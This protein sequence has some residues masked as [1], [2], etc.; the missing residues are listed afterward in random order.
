MPLPWMTQSPPPKGKPPVEDPFARYAVAAPAAQEEDPFAQYAVAAPRTLPGPVLD[1][2]A[3]SEEFTDAPP[4]AKSWLDTALHFASNA[5]QQLDPRPALKLI[6]DG[7]QAFNPAGGGDAG[8]GFVQDLKGIGGAQLEQFK[9]GKQAYDEGRISEAIGHT[10]AGVVPLMGPVAGNIGEQAGSGDISGALGA[11]TGLALGAKVVPKVL[12]KLIPTKI[13]GLA[14]LTAEEAAAVKQAQAA[15]VVVDAGTATGNAFVKGAQAVSDHSPLGSIVA[16]KAYLANAQNLATMGEQLAAKA[17]QTAEIGPQ[18]PGVPRPMI[19]GASVSAEQAGRSAQQAMG[20][21]VQDEQA[22]AIRAQVAAADTLDARG[23]QLADA[24]H[25]VPQT[26]ESAGTASIQGGRDVVH[27]RNVEASDAY[28]QLRAIEADPANLNTIRPAVAAPRPDARAMFIAQDKAPPNAIFLEALKDAKRSGFTGTAGELKGIFDERVKTAKA[29]KA[30]TESAG[31]EYGH[32][33]FLKSI[34]ELGGLK[35]YI[36]DYVPGAPVVKMTGE[37]D[38]VKQLFKGKG[39]SSIFR[40]KGLGLDDMVGQLRQDPRWSHVLTDESDLIAMLDDIGTKSRDG[41][42]T[43]GGDLQH[44]LR[45]A[46]VEPGVKWWETPKPPVDIPMATDLREFKSAI[47]PAFNDLKQQADLVPFMDGSGKATAYRALGRLIDGPDHA[48]LSVVDAALGELKSFARTDNPDLRSVGQGVA[49]AAIKKLDAVVRQTAWDAGPHALEALD[50]GRAATVAK[51]AA[52]DVLKR[53]EASNAE[54]VKAFGRLTAKA[55][56][57]IEHLREVVREVPHAAPQIGRA[58]IDG[59]LEQKDTAGS[60]DRAGKRAADWAALGPE[61][62]TL[63]FGGPEKVQ[64]LDRLFTTGSK[65]AEAH[66]AVAASAAEQILKR[67]SPGAAEPVGA[68]RG[69]TGTADSDI[70]HLRD[71]I[72]HAP[73]EAGKIGRAVLDGIQDEARAKTGNFEIT[74]TQAATWEKLGPETKRLLYRDPVYIKELDRYFAN[75]RRMSERANPSMSAVVGANMLGASTAVTS[76]VTGHLAAIPIL[77]SG[78]A[79]S[80][81]LHT[82]TGVRL[83]SEG[84]RLPTKSAAAVAQYTARVNA[85]LGKDAPAAAPVLAKDGDQAPG[86]V[87]LRMRK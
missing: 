36:K 6:Y 31:M 3:T 58:V 20:A 9:K 63:L 79:V 66:G 2:P 26:P 47:Q 60:F 43:G 80:K 76:A 52:A 85:V 8:A 37:F 84:L 19:P 30:E 65:L 34:R 59:I 69:L 86:E 10:V 87:Y 33:E 82:T 21:I 53:L 81:L 7:A 68:F 83:L 28:G 16:R 17:N 64:A 75:I 29:L 24:T 44:Y 12:P 54:P 14:N 32:A 70:A 5:G 46:G 56:T 11:M 35:P 55:D 18:L 77:A 48:P 61:T 71:V 50:T 22:A 78:Y 15:G 62:K 45:G 39:A 4:P 57:N 51:Y 41:V 1:H 25:P 40:D 42:Q 38:S 67:L 49:A 74:A 72:R 13:G 27:A 73:D 23:R